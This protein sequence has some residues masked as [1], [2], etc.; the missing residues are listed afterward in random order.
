[1]TLIT[2]SKQERETVIKELLSVC[3]ILGLTVNPKKSQVFNYTYVKKRLCQDNS[4]VMSIIPSFYAKTFHFLGFYLSYTSSGTDSLGLIKEHMNEVETIIQTKNCKPGFAGTAIPT[5]LQGA[6]K[7]R[8]Q[9]DCLTQTFIKNIDKK[10]NKLIRRA[11]RAL[12]LLATTLIHCD[13]RIEGLGI[14]SF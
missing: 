14:R 8:S 13:R 11:Y 9:L 10:I 2:G 5:I 4:T 12:P 7:Y 1:L 6:V 3:K